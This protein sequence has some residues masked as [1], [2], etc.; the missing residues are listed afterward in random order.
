MMATLQ[1]TLDSARRLCGVKR[2]K[3][4]AR[5]TDESEL[6]AL[7]ARR[8]R[9]GEIPAHWMKRPVLVDALREHKDHPMF[10]ARVEEAVKVEIRSGVYHLAWVSEEVRDCYLAG[11]ITGEIS[12]GS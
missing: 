9:D 1:L 11:I 6:I 7:L 12:I 2:F 5:A 4:S 3:L 10:V 8:I